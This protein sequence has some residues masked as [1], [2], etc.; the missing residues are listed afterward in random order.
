MAAPSRPSRRD[1][2]HRQDQEDRKL[3]PLGPHQQ[4]A[5]IAV[6]GVA[7]RQDRGRGR[8]GADQQRHREQRIVGNG[9]VG[10]EREKILPERQQAGDHDARQQGHQHRAAGIEASQPLL[11][12]DRM[13]VAELGSQRK[14][15]LDAEHPQ[16]PGDDAGEAPLRHRDAIGHKRTDQQHRQIEQR[17]IGGARH[18]ERSRLAKLADDPAPRMRRRAPRARYGNSRGASIISS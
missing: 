2:D 1:Q 17:Q 15:R 4:I 7:Q 3:Q 11:V 12:A 18:R 8:G 10:P 6:I 14:G 9:A 5:T 13:I 16:Q